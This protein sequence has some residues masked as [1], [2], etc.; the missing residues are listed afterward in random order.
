[1]SSMMHRRII[2][3]YEAQQ[4]R[5][6][7]VSGSML[8]RIRAVPMIIV[9]VVVALLNEADLRALMLTSRGFGSG[10]I[11]AWRCARPTIND[12]VIIAGLLAT[13]GFSMIL[14]QP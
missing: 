2:T 3:T 10:T 1:M 4:S 5:G 7:Q 8:T 11:I 12:L 14:V 13:L 9:P 6:L